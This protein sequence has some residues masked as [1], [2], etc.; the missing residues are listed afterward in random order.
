MT[1]WP[2]W[3]WVI[4]DGDSPRSK[5]NPALSETKGRQSSWLRFERIDLSSP[6]SI[7]NRATVLA[8]GSRGG[9]GGS[10]FHGLL[11]PALVL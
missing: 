4:V 7:R 6:W 10:D 3:S 11:V 1:R 9:W 5:S 2:R 8:L